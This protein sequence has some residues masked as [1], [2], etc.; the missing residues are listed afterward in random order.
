MV[1]AVLSCSDTELER[2]NDNLIFRKPQ[3]I[4]F[5][6]IFETARTWSFVRGF[7]HALRPVDALVWGQGV[8][9][10]QGGRVGFPLPPGHRGVGERHVQLQEVLNV[11]LKTKV[12]HDERKLP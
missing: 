3:D 10:G 11:I 12:S 9:A 5:K 1:L 7:G 6:F 8:R 2:M 4:S